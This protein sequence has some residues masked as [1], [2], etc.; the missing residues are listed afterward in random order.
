[1]HVLLASRGGGAKG[2]IAIGSSSS[3]ASNSSQASSGGRPHVRG[4]PPGAG[5]AVAVAGFGSEELDADGSPHGDDP[6]NAQ[7][8]SIA[9]CSAK[10]ASWSLFMDIWIR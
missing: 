9:S 8:S 7:S 4:G 3:A 1:M 10:A 5:A 6:M 2:G